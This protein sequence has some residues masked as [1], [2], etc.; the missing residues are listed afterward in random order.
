[1]VH[2]A[3]VVNRPLP[4]HLWKILLF[5]KARQGIVIQLLLY[6]SDLLPYT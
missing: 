1:M 4:I 6:F 5:A 3:K 2:A